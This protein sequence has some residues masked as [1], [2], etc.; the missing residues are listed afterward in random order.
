MKQHLRLALPPL[1]LLST[2]TN[3]AFVLIDRHGR[4]ARQGELPP[5][6]LAT[7]VGSHPVYAVLHPHDAI[8]AQVTVPPVSSQR[9]GAA[10]AGSIEP[11]LLSDIEQLCVAHGPRRPN[12]QVDVAW[13]TRRQLADAWALLADAGLD[14]V[15]FIPHGLAVPKD[16]PNPETPLALPAGQ[17]W[18]G[19][20][21]SWSLAHESLRPASAGGRWRK[22]VWWTTAA[23]AVWVLGLNA[24]ASRLH[25]EVHSLQNDMRLAVTQ[26]FPHIPVVIDPVRQAQNQR[27][28]LRL[29]QGVSADDDFMPLALATAQVLDFAQGHVRRLQ[30]EQGE[31][32]LTLAEG[33]TPPANE[34]SLAQAAAVQQVALVKDVTGPH[35]WRIRRVEPAARASETS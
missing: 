11:M 21:P 13:A 2:D 12:G 1:E 29:A 15:A 9:L 5:V 10:V 8:V 33:Y 17:R 30:Y 19:P 7:Q 34:A 18:T 31:L 25:D 28:A 24:Y 26:A 27:D 16:D 20:L 6:G 14:V 35:V 22:A 23:A 3:L 4:I 32:I